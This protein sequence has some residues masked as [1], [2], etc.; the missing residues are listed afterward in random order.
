[1][2]IESDLWPSL[3]RVSNNF[4]SDNCVYPAN[5]YASHD[6]LQGSGVA[7]SQLSSHMIFPRGHM[8]EYPCWNHSVCDKTIVLK[9]QLGFYA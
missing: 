4:V 3:K 8:I 9:K 6:Y 1:M 5:I 2:S 7:Y